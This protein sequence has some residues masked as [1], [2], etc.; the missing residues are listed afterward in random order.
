MRLEFFRSGLVCMILSL[1]CACKQPSDQIEIKPLARFIWPQN[2][3]LEFE[4][5]PKQAGEPIDLLYQVQVDPAYRYQNIWLAYWLMA[6]D[7]DTLTHS[8]D[9]LTLYHQSGKPVGTSIRERMI[10]EA[11]FLKNITLKKEGKYRLSLKHYMREDSLR[12]VQSIGVRW[13]T[14]S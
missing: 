13:Q 8:R 6:P 11:F 1:L 4:L 10:V 3:N 9:N 2:Q 12:G 5:E 7:G 14:S